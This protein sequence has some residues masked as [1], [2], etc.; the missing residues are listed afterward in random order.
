MAAFSMDLRVRI[1]E[2]RDAG[3][4]TSEIAER[5]DVSPA[6]VRRLLQRHRESGSL[7]PKSGPRGPQPKLRPQYEAIR[8]KIAEYPDLTAAEVRDQ[9]QLR[10][11]TQTVWRALVALGL[12]FKKRHSKRP[13]ANATMSKPPA[14]SGQRPFASR[15][16]SA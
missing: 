7:A 1:F 6:F 3:E 4:S 8:T 2:A 12:T 5:F 9:L 15:P 10:A 13:N 11:S 14:N 16:L